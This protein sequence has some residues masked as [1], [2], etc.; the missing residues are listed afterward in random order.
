[1]RRYCPYLIVLILLCSVQL[2]NAQTVLFY[3]DF[4]T[5]Y[6]STHLMTNWCRTSSYSNSSSG[7]CD[8]YSWYAYGSG[9]YISTNDIA[10]P[11]TGT[12]ELSFDYKFDKTY[13]FPVVEISSSGCYGTYTSV[14]T[15]AN[16]TTCFTETVDLSAYAGQTINIRFYTNSSLGTFVVD[17]VDVSNTSGGGG[18][19]CTDLF[20][21]DFGTSYSSTFLMAKWCSAS[22]YSNSSSGACDGYSWYAYGS[23]DYIRSDAISIPATGTSELTFDY[24][25]NQFSSY[26]TVQV[27]TSGCY[28]T[29]STVSTLQYKS[30]CFTETVDL[31]VYAGQTIHIRFY[32]W[33]SSGTFILDNVLVQNCTSGGSAATDDFKW[34]DNFN[35]NDLD[36]DFTGNDGDEDYSGQSWDIGT[37]SLAGSYSSTV[38]YNKT[39][40]FPDSQTQGYSIQVDKGEYFESPTVDLFAAESLKISFYID[41]AGGT[42]TDWIG[43]HVYLQIWDGSAWIRALSLGGGSGDDEDLIASGFGYHCFTAYKTT[44]SPGNYYYSFAPNVYSGYF[45]SDFK[46]R[47]EVQGYGGVAVY[48]DNFT[49][50][51]DNDGES[52]IPCGISYWNTAD[53]TY[54]GK[55]TDGAKSTTSAIK[56]MEVEIDDP[57]GIG[58]PPNWAGHCNDGNIGT[59]ASGYYTVWAVVAEQEVSTTY[60]KLYYTNGTTNNNVSMSQDNSYAGPGYLY[61]YKLFTGCNGE[62]GAYDPDE[63][64]S[65]AFWFDF[66]SNMPSVYYQLNSSGIEKGGGVTSSSEYLAPGLVCSSVLP[67]EIID[68]TIVKNDEDNVLYWSTVSEFNNSHFEVE[69]SVD[70]LKFVNIGEV[71][72]NGNSSNFINYQFLDED[73]NTS[74][75]YRLKQVDFDG[76][77]KY[78][79]IIFSAVTHDDLKINVVNGNSV[80]INF[81]FQFTG[82]IIICDLSGKK[83]L[84]QTLIDQKDIRFE[85]NN[86]GLFILYF[87]S[88]EYIPAKKILIQ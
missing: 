15:L 11:A 10:I 80:N 51:A 22:S 26:P 4:G 42:V 37:A 73:V 64:L 27:S 23:G 9:D 88:D 66:G 68:F 67:V 45:H 12:T 60:S 47:I 24:K 36:L 79:N 74:N 55:D 7:A 49:F 40:A 44:S 70:R 30:S 59:D 75:Y 76:A 29:Y 71:K 82:D 18:T 83:L 5:S 63:G 61:Y 6:S 14:K 21:D 41:K 65:Y 17:N 16:K 46:F 62:V 39:E 2:L 8:G 85:L 72:G 35:D 78:S 56:G 25:F 52:V 57:F 48:V 19:T 33:N 1:M 58:T 54:Y 3:E 50:R 13:S 87:M 81:G 32:T 28:G 69:R 34:A 53:A 84:S 86:K 43:S 31:S 38:N 77:Y 20:A